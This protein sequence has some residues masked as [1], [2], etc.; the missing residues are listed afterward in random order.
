M[1]LVMSIPTY[2]ARAGEAR[3]DDVVYDHPT[4]LDEAGTLGRALESLAILEDREFSLVIVVA[5]TAQ[6]IADAAMQKVRRIVEASHPGVE[7]FLISTGHAGAIRERV[8]GE[9][10]VMVSCFGYPGVRNMSLIAARLLRAE[11]VVLIDDDELIEDMSF[12]GKVRGNFEAGVEGL[13]GYYVNADGGFRLKPAG[14]GWEEGLG[15]IEAMNAAFDQLI[16]GPPGL[17][18]TPLAFGGAMAMTRSLFEEVPFDPLITRGEDIDYVFNARVAGVTFML[19]NTLAVRHLPPPHSAPPWRQLQQDLLRF[20]YHRQ[21]LRDSAYCAEDFDPYP[22]VFL[23]DDLEKRF[24]RALAAQEGHKGS[25]GAG[26]RTF[27][28]AMGVYMKRRRAWAEM[29]LNLAPAAGEPLL[30]VV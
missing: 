18:E 14:A 22:G 23:R 29:M 4:P 20:T 25:A 26:R 19:D 1:K 3:E 2:W 28:D 9:A 21:K 16:G 30:T 8:A 15:K 12:L 5:P 7:T 6:D 11:G 27:P 13:A 24:S 10:A 17:R